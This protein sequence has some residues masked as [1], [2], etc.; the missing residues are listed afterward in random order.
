MIEYHL[1]FTFSWCCTICTTILFLVV[2]LLDSTVIAEES[3]GNHV[4][5]LFLID[6]NE[7]TINKISTDGKTVVGDFRNSQG[8]LEG[9]VWT[10]D[11]GLLPLGSLGG[12]SGTISSAKAVSADGS[13]V[14]GLAKTAEQVTGNGRNRTVIPSRDQAFIW[15]AETGM[16]GLGSLSG[17]SGAY[18]V[19]ADG[20]VVAG[21]SI[22]ANGVWEPFRWTVETGMVGLG[23]L[24]ASI[25]VYSSANVGNGASPISSDGTTIVGRGWNGSQHM[26]YVWTLDGGYQW[27]STVNTFSLLSLDG[28]VA[29]G[30]TSSSMLVDQGYVW[31]Q[32]TGPLSMGTVT[33]QV[34]SEPTGISADGSLVVGWS[35]TRGLAN[36]LPND[37]FVWDWAG[38]MR[39]LPK[40]SDAVSTG[41]WDASLDGSVIAGGVFAGEWNYNEEPVLWFRGLDSESE[42]E[43]YDLHFLRDILRDGGV[44]GVD[45]FGDWGIWY[46][47][48]D[49]NVVAGYTY[50][51]GD[52]GIPFVAV[53]DISKLGGAEHDESDDDGDEDSGDDGDEDGEEEHGDDD[54][55]AGLFTASVIYEATGPGGR[56]LDVTV[57]VSGDD[58]PISGA[59][60]SATLR[61]LTR[62]QSWN[63][64]GTT[65]ANGIF[66]FRRSNASSGFYVLEI[67]SVSHPD[68]EWNGQI[69]DPGHQQ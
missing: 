14:V 26:A 24:G 34:H 12:N 17:V 10:I 50:E 65:N 45:A 19:S 21:E 13:V 22:N 48:G 51:N 57:A 3:P 8:N 47:S 15:T 27:V 54:G 20:T 61:N 63:E 62:G 44:Q 16:V 7:I 2:P 69:D 5:A 38:D 56:H 52:F 39:S 33:P 64:S 66:T 28:T 37:A 67:H 53:L 40:P 29:A 6:G 42:Q 18:G 49:G 9:F 30:F 41:A 1:R 55:D 43:F 46:T 11:G 32:A 4:S 59:A 36:E 60:V 58:G 35:F 31:T 25:R 68:Y 23:T